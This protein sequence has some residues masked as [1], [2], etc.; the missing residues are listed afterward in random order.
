VFLA[1]RSLIVP[2][3]NTDVETLAPYVRDKMI[4]IDIS[5][6]E[7]YTDTHEIKTPTRMTKEAK[8]DMAAIMREVFNI[9][10]R[11]INEIDKR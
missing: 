3:N 4:I 9:F 10:E 8:L 7:G 2:A 6:D 1:I 5:R 11:K